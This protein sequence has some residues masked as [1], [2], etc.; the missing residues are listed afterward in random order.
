[1]NPDN[2]TRQRGAG[3]AVLLLA[4]AL[5][6]VAMAAGERPSAAGTA[7]P[8]RATAS[9]SRATP[10]AMSRCA[11]ARRHAPWTVNVNSVNVEAGALRGKTV[12]VTGRNTQDV[13]VQDC[14][15]H[16]PVS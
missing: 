8:P 11:A 1:M 7:T 3:A 9:W 13:R 16:R 4:L 6:A 10:P 5:P 2:S 12:I 14:P 15:G